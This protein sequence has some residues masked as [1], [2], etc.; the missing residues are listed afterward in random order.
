MSNGSEL[1]FLLGLW[2][3]H[4]FRANDARKELTHL[5]ACESWILEHAQH[6]AEC[7]YWA[8]RTF[9]S[10]KFRYT[11]KPCTCGLAKIMEKM[12]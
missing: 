10:L 4:D 7:T 9:G 12:P 8:E 2:P 6:G 3:G 5:R 11:P 1:D